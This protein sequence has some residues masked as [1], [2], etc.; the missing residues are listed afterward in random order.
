MLSE[1]LGRRG[2]PISLEA[3]ARQGGGGGG[4]GRGQRRDLTDLPTFTVDPATARDFDDAVSAR[5]EGDG[6]PALDPHRRRRR[7]RHPGLARSTARRGGAANSTYVAGDGRADAAARAQRGRLQPRAGGRAARGDGRDRARRAAGA[8]GRVASTAAGSAPTPGSTTTSSIAS[9]PAAR[10]APEGG[11]RAAGAGPR[12]RGPARR[13]ERA[14][15]ASRSSRPSPSSSFDRSGDVVGGPVGAADRVPPPDRAADDPHQRAG[16]AA[17]GAAAGPGHLPRP[18]PARPA[19][20]GTDDRPAR[21]LS[22]SRPRRCGA[23]WR[24]ARRETWRPRRAGWSRGRPNGA[25]MAAR[26]I[27]LSCSD[28]SKQASY[29]ERNSGHAGL[30]S[31]AYC[32]FT[33]PIRRYPDLVVHRALLA[34]VGEG[35]SAPASERPA[36]WPATAARASATR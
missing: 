34:A 35:E 27:H 2:F 22:A 13:A 6:D 17:A 10:A 24:R 32:H 7:P 19:P 36:R 1:E 8:A 12:G 21:T 18:R 25:A 20:G 5:R 11:R 28:R 15:E 30:G 4:R 31:A 14:T 3:E 26:R 9:S 33:S 23:R 16:R 29:S